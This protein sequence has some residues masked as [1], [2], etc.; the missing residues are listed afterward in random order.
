NAHKRTIRTEAA[1]ALTWTK[2]MRLMIEVYCPRNKI[3]KMKSELWNMTIKGN[4]L[5]AYTHRFQ[6]LILLYPKMV[7]EEED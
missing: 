7:P 2:L 1:Y 4:D 3:Q 6:E 5:T